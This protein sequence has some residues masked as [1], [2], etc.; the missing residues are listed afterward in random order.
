MPRRRRRLTGLRTLAL[1]AGLLTTLAACESFGLGE[2]KPDAPA[3]GAGTDSLLIAADAA[4]DQ[5]RIEDAAVLLGRIL[6]TEPNNS[7]AK[8][9][10]AEIYLLSNRLMLAAASFK[11]LS[12]VSDVRAKALQ[13]FGIAMMKQGDLDA[14]H[15]S[16]TKAVDEDA[17]LW[18]AWNA[19]GLYYDSQSLW[20]D[21]GESYKQALAAKP[22]LALI[23]NNLGYSLL[24]QRKFT[25]ATSAFRK[26]LRLRPALTAARANLRL[27]L[28]WE[29]K[30]Q[31]A[32]AGVKQGELP[33]V[34]NDVGYIAILRGDYDQAEAL[35][36][37]AMVESPTFNETASKNL[38]Y[39]KNIKGA[40]K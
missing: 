11:H 19:L 15:E 23:H 5:R 27:S 6:K 1:S 30:Y 12:T 22:K 2:D 7:Q 4:V 8:L 29:G 17:S 35:L 31:E 3:A 16:L 39:V 32:T 33:T 38:G 18:R 14:A 34:L 25:D 26:A 36:S 28:A 37:R 21:A 13:G 24:M 10:I 20:K 9:R 40:K